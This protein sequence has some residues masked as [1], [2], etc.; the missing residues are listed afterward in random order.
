[1]QTKLSFYSS[2][3]GLKPLGGIDFL[4]SLLRV[5]YLDLRRLHPTQCKT[6]RLQ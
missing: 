1:M 2:M 4:N 3:A 6:K 5:K